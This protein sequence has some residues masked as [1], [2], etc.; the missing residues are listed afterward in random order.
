M[1]KDGEL[2]ED[3]KEKGDPALRDRLESWVRFFFNTLKITLK[4]KLNSGT[5]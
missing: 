4:T 1:R 2:L 3:K 5:Q